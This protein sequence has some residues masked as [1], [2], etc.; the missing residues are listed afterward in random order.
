LNLTKNGIQSIP[1]DQKGEIRISVTK[2]NGFVRI[3][4][5][6]NGTGI[7]V[8]AQE[9]LFEPNFTTKTSGMGLG[10]SIVHNI[11][12]TAGGRIWYET[13]ANSGTTFFVE[14]PVNEK[15]GNLVNNHS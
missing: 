2:S 13:S 6:D 8:E 9:H 7:G 11:I 15:A 5:S 4:F 12:A 14:I 1:G 10:L 3:A